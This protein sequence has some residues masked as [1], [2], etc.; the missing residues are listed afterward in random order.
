MLMHYPDIPSPQLHFYPSILHFF[1]CFISSN[2]RG[3]VTDSL[4]LFCCQ[5]RGLHRK[6]ERKRFAV[7]ELPMR[8]RVTRHLFAFNIWNTSWLG[9]YRARRASIIRNG[10]VKLTPKDKNNWMIRHFEKQN[11][12]I[13]H[14]NAHITL[15][16]YQNFLQLT[17]TLVIQDRV[18]HSSLSTSCYE[19]WLVFNGQSR[20]IQSM[21][22]V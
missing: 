9:G 11:E 21:R 3:W 19:E 13:F 22:I 20:V 16:F 2:K 12:L 5:V 17:S 18:Q 15:S 7:T 1:P 6:C 8:W 10:T 14:H 4:V